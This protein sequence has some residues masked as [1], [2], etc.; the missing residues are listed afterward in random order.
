MRL[1]PVAVLIMLLLLPAGA[2]AGSAT[3][4]I[5]EGCSYRTGS[6]TVPPGKVAVSIQAS[7]DTGWLPCAGTGHATRAGVRLK[8]PAGNVIYYFVRT[9][10]GKEQVL[11]GSLAG[12]RLGPGTYT[13]EAP[14]GGL[15]TTATVSFDLQDAAPPPPPPAVAAAGP[16]GAGS[17]SGDW[18]DPSVK[19]AARIVHSGSAMTITNTFQWEGKTVTWTGSGTVSGDVV[20]FNYSYTGFRPE[21]WE[22]GTMTLR[23]TN[24]RTLSGSWTTASGKFS[25]PITFVQTRSDEPGPA[26]PSG[27]QKAGPAAHAPA[28]PAPAPGAPRTPARGRTICPPGQHYE[29]NVGC[30]PYFREA[31]ER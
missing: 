9:Y 1:L 24:S 5:G 4:G 8:G 20:K 16:G 13:V 26:F 7:V 29:E 17:L 3:A 25:Q 22:D 30:T 28:A 21:G 10:E 14:D 31:E 23:R 27:Q 19:S 11:A 6:F 2:F 12:L 15:G 18:S